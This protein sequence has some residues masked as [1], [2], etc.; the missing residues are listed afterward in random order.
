MASRKDLDGY[1]KMSVVWAHFVRDKKKFSE[2]VKRK[3]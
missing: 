3:S 2:I 1:F